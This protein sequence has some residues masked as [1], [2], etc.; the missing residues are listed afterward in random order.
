MNGASITNSAP[1]TFGGAPAAPGPSWSVAG[2][3]DF[4]ADG[5]ADIL[6]RDSSGSLVEWLMNGAHIIGNG[7]VTSGGASVAPDGHIAR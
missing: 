6:W 1:V 5:N 4:N 7:P 3:G 2:V